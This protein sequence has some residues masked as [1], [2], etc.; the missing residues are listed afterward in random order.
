MIA[1]RI[2]GALTVLATPAMAQQR[3]QRQVDERVL[4]LAQAVP[5][6]SRAPVVKRLGQL[7]T[8]EAGSF[9]IT[10]GQGMPYTILAV[11]DD[12][13]TRLQL[14]LLT[15]SGSDVAKERNSE[16]FPTLHVTPQATMTYR[17]RVVMEGCRW[18]PCW[19]AVAVIPLGRNT[20]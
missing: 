14:T 10:L 1:I 13:C 11:C 19:Y 16:S 2:L 12:D 7:N 20:P 8:D 9:Q 18:N 15:S 6:L 17:I 5:R 3:W 4:R